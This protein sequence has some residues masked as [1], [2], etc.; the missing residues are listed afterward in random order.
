MKGIYN[1]F[2]QRLGKNFVNTTTTKYKE[3]KE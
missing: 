2:S 1:E 3:V